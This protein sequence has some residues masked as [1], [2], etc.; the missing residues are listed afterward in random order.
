[1]SPRRHEAGQYL[2]RF[3]QNSS[4]RDKKSLGYLSPTREKMALSLYL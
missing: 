3:V 4:A 1:M 2:S